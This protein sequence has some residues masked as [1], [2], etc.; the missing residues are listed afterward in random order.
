VTRHL[1]KTRPPLR[2]SSG[3]IR[4]SS[5][6]TK[7]L[8]RSSGGK[9]RTHRRSGDAIQRSSGEI[10]RT[11]GNL[12]GGLAGKVDLRVPLLVC[13]T[14]S[15]LFGLV[16]F[17]CTAVSRAYRALQGPRFG[18]GASH[19]RRRLHRPYS[20]IRPL[21]SHAGDRPPQSRGERGARGSPLPSEGG[22]P[23]VPI[24][25]PERGCAPGGSAGA[26]GK[27]MGRGL[28]TQGPRP[29]ACT[30]MP[31]RPTERGRPRTCPPKPPPRR[32][33]GPRSGCRASPTASGT[34]PCCA[35]AR[36]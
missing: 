23:Q 6:Q 17:R 12:R 14:L 35:V 19:R 29:R 8:R 9:N 28:G 11:S 16:L 15:P 34:V 3:T 18:G 24:L 26:A 27:G 25:G 31:G 32:R 22:P 36:G 21:A 13:A 2:R 7:A 20:G 4:R 10:Q 30:G 33:A 5:S 1:L